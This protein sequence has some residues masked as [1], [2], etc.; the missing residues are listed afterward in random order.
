MKKTF[1]P[2]SKQF[3]LGDWFIAYSDLGQVGQF[4][5]NDAKTNVFYPAGD[6]LDYAFLGS[7][8]VGEFGF[9]YSLS[10]VGG[11]LTY[12][13]ELL[14]DNKIK[15][16]FGG[17]AYGAGL[18]HWTTKKFQLLLTPFGVFDGVTFNL[19]TD[20]PAN[21]TYIILTQEDDPKNVVKLHKEMILDTYK[22]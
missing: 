11:V 3:A 8:L 10:G 21:P 7:S 19:T 2:L 15:L 1:P 18:T 12:K 22:K 17:S 13:V 9:N 4:Y 14:D 20:N 6:V 16:T 5:Y